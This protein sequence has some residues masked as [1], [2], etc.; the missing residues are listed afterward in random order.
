MIVLYFVLTAPHPKSCLLIESIYYLLTLLRRNT[1]SLMIQGRENSI[2]EGR[3]GSP[4][5]QSIRECKKVY[6]AAIG[7]IQEVTA[8]ER[9]LKNCPSFAKS[10]Q[11]IK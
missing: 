8:I 3:W 10:K 9:A 4:N 5:V 11:I 6:K 2:I 7:G 1:N